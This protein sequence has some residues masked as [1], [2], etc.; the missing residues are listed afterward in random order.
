MKESSWKDC[1]ESNSSISVSKDKAK[2]KSLIDTASGRNQFLSRNKID[3]N[4]ANYIFEGYYSS[5]VEL[6]HALVLLNGYKVGNHICL[7]FYLRD[8]M[9][10]DS[11]FRIFDDCRFKRNSLVYYG[12]KMD[13][14]TAKEAVKRCKEL[15]KEINKMLEK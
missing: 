9:N 3:E 2:A 15:I 13:F 12:R 14:E 7:G 8:V 5:L 11:L 6:M 1:I 10:K 4:N